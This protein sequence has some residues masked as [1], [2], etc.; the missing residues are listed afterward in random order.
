MDTES[1]AMR[2][3]AGAVDR[4]AGYLGGRGFRC[5]ELLQELSGQSGIGAR[6]SLCAR[7]HEAL[8]RLRL[9]VYLRVGEVRDRLCYS[10]V[11]GME[12]VRKTQFFR[13]LMG[14]PW[15]DEHLT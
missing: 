14:P 15:G 11:K 12:K 1:L 4:E 13:L 3:M 8:F 6:T 9:R 7:P 5:C 10:K 2:E